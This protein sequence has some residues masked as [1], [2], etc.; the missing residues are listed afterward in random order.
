[1]WYFDVG[2]TPNIGV[3]NIVIPIIANILQ[4]YCEKNLSK[5]LFIVQVPCLMELKFGISSLFRPVFSLYIVF[6]ALQR[7]GVKYFHSSKEVSI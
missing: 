7:W 6:G 2:Q 3:I 5:K 4:S 1:M